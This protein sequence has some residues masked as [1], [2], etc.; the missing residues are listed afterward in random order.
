[1]T[2]THSS[3]QPALL[4]LADG[5]TWPGLALGRRGER[6]GEIVFNTSITGYQEIL[7]DPSYH[8]QIVVLTQPHIGNYGV[9]DADDESERDWAAGLVVRAASPIVSN[10]RAAR[11]LD[12][13]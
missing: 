4:A 12:D 6:V 1:M 10:W 9:N 5:T 3:P 11:S 8:G 13:Y 2:E 7:T